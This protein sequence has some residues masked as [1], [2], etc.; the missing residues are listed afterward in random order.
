[1][2][3]LDNYEF[4]N[5][6]FMDHKSFL[7]CSF[8]CRPLLTAKSPSKWSGSGFEP[9]TTVWCTNNDTSLLF[10][11]PGKGECVDPVNGAAI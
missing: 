4:L 11:I 3:V 10:R 6:N 5:Q 7:F 2:R 9:G 8:L 1:M